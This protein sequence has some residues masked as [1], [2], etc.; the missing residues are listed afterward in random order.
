MLAGI[1]HIGDRIMEVNDLDV[2]GLTVEV[3]QKMLVNNLINA[4]NYA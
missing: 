3:L 2:Q 4:L 1:L